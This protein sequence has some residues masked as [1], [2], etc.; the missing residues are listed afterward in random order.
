MTSTGR[1]QHIMSHIRR[2]GAGKVDAFAEQF[3]VSAVTIRHDLNLLEKEGCVFRCYGGATLNPNFAFDQPLYR[4]DQLNRSIKQCIAQ[5]AAALI[6]HGDTV[7]LDSGSTIAL[8]PQYLTQK[9][10]VVMTNALNTAYQLSSND[11]VELHVVGGN[12]RRA[13]CSL[14]G[15]HGEEQ[16]RAYFFD[17]LFLGVDGFDLES[18][19]TTP[20]PGEAQINRAMCD[21]SRQIIAVT[22]SSKFGRKSFCMIRAAAQIDVLVTDSRIPHHVHRALQELGVTVILADQLTQQE[23]A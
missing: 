16:I 11:N 6:T 1:R 19:I 21:V 9:K 10:L 7:I 4:K 20:D 18:G 15:N 22:D 23:H 3:N 5:A 12:L 17:K 8:M 13:S 2:H 14:I